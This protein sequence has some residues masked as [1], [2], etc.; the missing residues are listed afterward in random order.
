MRRNYKKVGDSHGR[1]SGEIMK[2]TDRVKRFCEEYLIDANAAK[3]ATRAGYA[4]KYADRQGWRIL[5]DEDV[6]AYIAARMEEKN[7]EL[8]AS[9][10]EVLKYLTKV[11]RGDELDEKVVFDQYGT[12][13]KVTIRTQQ[14]QI[15]AAEL[16]AKRYGLLN[17]KVNITGAVPVIISG[18]DELKD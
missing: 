3:A 9:Q 11:I 17:D 5:Q 4:P 8:I 12:A 10:D 6:K 15:K 14:N 7:K 16:M 1:K 18:E 2:M 13:S